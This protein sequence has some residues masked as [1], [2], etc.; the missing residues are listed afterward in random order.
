VSFLVM[1]RVA[2]AQDACQGLTSA[3]IPRATIIG[4]TSVP[5][6]ATTKAPAFCEVRATL[7]PAPGSQIGA[8]YRLPLNWNGKVLGVGG[9]G[10]AGNVTLQGAVEGLSRGYAVIQ[11]DMGHASANATDW[12]FAITAPGKPNVEAVIDFGHRATHEATV[13]GKVVVSRFY[14][15]PVQRSYWEGCS[16]GGRRG[17]PS[18]APRDTTA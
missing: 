7:S 16:T 11:N 6:N 3:S 15:R 12:S 8:V 5:A 4:A 9:G 1:P 10:S 17:W 14:G 13:A 18:A 2:L